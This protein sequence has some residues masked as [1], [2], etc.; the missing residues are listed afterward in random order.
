MFS[1]LKYTFWFTQS[2]CISFFILF[3]FWNISFEF[4]KCMTF[5]SLLPFFVHFNILLVQKCM[6]FLSLLPFFAHFNILLV[7]KC[8][9]FL[10]LL[11][12]FAHFNILLVQKCITFL[13]LLPF[14]AHFNILLVQNDYQLH[15]IEKK[16]INRFSLI[17][18]LG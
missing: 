14:F 7:Q 17:S 8:M 4:W 6:T 15:K 5:L 3:Y 18:S 10:S 9:T 16:I 1:W 2:N 13:S 12:F 11:P